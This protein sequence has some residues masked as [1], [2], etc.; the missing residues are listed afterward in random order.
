MKKFLLSICIFFVVSCGCTPAKL[1]F[2]EKMKLPG[3]TDSLAE[4]WYDPSIKTF[5][6]YEQKYINKQNTK[7]IAIVKVRCSKVTHYIEVF[8]DGITYRD[9]KLHVCTINTVTI[10]DIFK[11]Y[12]GDFYQ[13]NQQIELRQNY[14]YVPDCWGKD[15]NSFFKKEYGLT[16]EEILARPGSKYPVDLTKDYGYSLISPFEG[17]VPLDEG[18]EYLMVLYCRSLSNDGGMEYYISKEVPY[19]IAKYKDVFNNKYGFRFADYDI[20]VM[21]ALRQEFME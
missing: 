19:N 6:D 21:N 15:S 10:T 4:R 3:C 8:V 13:V 18:E 11:I 2:E 7:D 12:G 1:T 9:P 5:E 14:G 16:K 17:I 20:N